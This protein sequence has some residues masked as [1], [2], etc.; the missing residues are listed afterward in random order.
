MNALIGEKLPHYYNKPQT[1]RKNTWNASTEITRSFFKIPRY[2][3]SEYLLQERMLDY[4]FQSVK[5]SELVLF[6]IDINADPSGTQTFDDERLS[7][8]N[9]VTDKRFCSSTR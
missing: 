7:V 5:D 1:T 2:S 6:I 9:E 8:L 4:V 3:K